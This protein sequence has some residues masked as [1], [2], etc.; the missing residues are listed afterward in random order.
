LTD[1]TG[2]ASRIR[3]T[4]EHYLW[5]SAQVRSVNSL[6]QTPPQVLEHGIELDTVSFSY[7]GSERPSLAGVSLLLP[8]GQVVAIVGENGAGKTTLV[9]LLCGMYEPDVG[10][11]LVDRVNLATI[12]IDA[13]RQRVTAGFQDYMQYE[14]TVREAVG[15]GDLPRIHDRAAI[16]AALTKSGATFTGQLPAGLQTQLGTSWQDGVDLSG[17]E[18]QKL[19]LARSMLRA[20][21]FL[22][23][24]DEPSA[25]LDPQTEHALFE[26]IAADA[27]QG[28]AHGR[29][30]LL[31]SHRFSTVRMADLIVVLHQG[32][33]RE[34]GS[35]DALIAQ[36]GLYAELFRLQAQA[37][38]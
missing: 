19:A 15:V 6:P 21:P 24:L 25:A 30:T 29:V 1:L 10:R 13:Y 8:A 16:D 36:D 20:N 28:S 3:A 22:V 14:L 7:T 27:R 5:L 32:R 4:S 23:I 12:D 37:Y 31:I 18:W 33:V 35:H 9:K 2:S 34:H 38:R 26:Q 17:G 11:I